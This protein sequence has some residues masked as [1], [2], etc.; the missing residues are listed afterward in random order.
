MHV[1]A[2]RSTT[3]ADPTY[4]GHGDGLNY[5]FV[6]EVLLQFVQ[7]QVLSLLKASR[8]ALFCFEC[9]LG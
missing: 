5:S 3:D 7:K 9:R 4:S 8:V 2:L 1:T 6:A